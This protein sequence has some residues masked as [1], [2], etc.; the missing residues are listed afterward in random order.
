MKVIKNKIALE[1]TYSKITSAKGLTM[2]LNS[3]TNRRDICFLWYNY[4]K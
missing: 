3:V 1:G 2:I 4:N